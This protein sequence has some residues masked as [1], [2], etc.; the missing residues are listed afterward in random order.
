MHKK[1]QQESQFKNKRV[2]FL[3]MRQKFLSDAKSDSFY[4]VSALVPSFV[5]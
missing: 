3:A 4:C 5:I 1:G 2:S